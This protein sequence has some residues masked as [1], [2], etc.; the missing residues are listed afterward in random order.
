MKSYKVVNGTYYDEN[1]PDEVIRVLENAR[2]NRQRI[3]VFYGNTITGQDWGEDCDTMGYVGRSCGEVKE[4]L[5]IKTKRSDGGAA[6]LT[7][8]IVKITIDKRTF[9]C[10]PNYRYPVLESEWEKKNEMFFTGMMNVTRA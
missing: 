8:C 10:H 2:K 1:T 9:Y 4:P 6:I 3:R 7:G 5:L